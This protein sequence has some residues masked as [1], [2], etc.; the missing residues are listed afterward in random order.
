MTEPR[1]PTCPKGYPA[2]PGPGDHAPARARRRAR[3]RPRASRSP[4]HSGLNVTDDAFYA[5][6]AEWTNQMTGTRPAERRDGERRP[7]RRGAAAWPAGGDDLRGLEQPRRGRERL[8]LA[9]SARRRLAS[10][11]R[12]RAEDGGRPRRC[13]RWR[14][15]AHRRS[16][17]PL[18]TSRARSG[19]ERAAALA[20]A[21]WHCRRRPA[22][23]RTALRDA[24]G[25]HADDVPRRT[26]RHAYPLFAH[27]R[28]RCGRIV[29]EAVEDAAADGVRAISSCASAPRRTRGSGM[30][31]RR[32]DRRGRATGVQGGDP[33]PGHRRRASSRARSAITTPRRTRQWP[34]PRPTSPAGASSASTSPGTSSSY[35]ALEPMR[36]AL[37]HRRGGRPGPDRA[38]RRGRNRPQHV[39]EAVETPRCASHRPRDRAQRRLR[40]GDGVGRRTRASASRSVPDLE[41]PHR[42]RAVVRGAPDPRGSWRRA[43]TS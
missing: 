19:R 41:R 36:A 27:A 23:G 30:S 9:R 21:H 26:S 25:G 20:A 13:D 12:G 8:R 39:R 40:R 29:A 34:E 11:H 32:G 5:E 6:S 31:A 43:A 4:L 17:P 42:C 18:P 28:C 16:E 24:R 22:V 37:R 2:V 1:T 35:P 3:S 38:R 10:Q 7:L 33:P 14:P 15:S